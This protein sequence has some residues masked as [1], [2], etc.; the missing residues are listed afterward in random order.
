M[1]EQVKRKRELSVEIWREL[2]KEGIYIP[3]RIQLNGSSMQPLIRK[4][5]DYVIIEPLKRSP[6]RGDIVLFS[7]DKGR[8]VVHRVKRLSKE[9]VI[10]Q[11][12]SC[13][14]EDTPLRY[15]Q[16]WGIVTKMERKNRVVIL[17]SAKARNAG[18]IWMAIL[19][20]RM[21]YYNVRRVAGQIYKK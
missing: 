8:Y 15:D 12:D 21:F 4:Q 7:D 17:N 16:I 1:K 14:T 6:M 13:T 5:R 2:S 18:K 19:P 11:G 3:V 9:F 10:T 20:I